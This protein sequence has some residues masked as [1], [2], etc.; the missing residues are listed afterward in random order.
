VQIAGWKRTLRRQQL[1]ERL[2]P[3]VDAVA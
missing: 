3:S 1:I 2:A